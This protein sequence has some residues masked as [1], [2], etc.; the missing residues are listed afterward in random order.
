MYCRYVCWRNYNGMLEKLQRLKT[1]PALLAT[2]Q[3]LMHMSLTS[4]KLM[5][6]W[7]NIYISCQQHIQWTILSRIVPIHVT[8]W[9][10]QWI[11]QKLWRVVIL[12]NKTMVFVTPWEDGSRSLCL[13]YCW[14]YS[15]FISML[16]YSITITC[17]AW[18]IYLILFIIIINHWSIY[19]SPFRCN[20]QTIRWAS[21]VLNYCHH[22]C[23][24]ITRYGLI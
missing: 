9:L 16:N 10:I 1:M 6:H 18:L 13:Y 11:A 21:N 14:L 20:N 12:Q 8:S 3:V 15:L 22:S 19:S 2:D 4:P 17:N 23:S 24:L 5:S 7:H